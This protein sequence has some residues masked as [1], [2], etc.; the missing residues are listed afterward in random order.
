MIIGNSFFRVYTQPP[1][2]SSLIRKNMSEETPEEVK[3]TVPPV[4]QI[5]DLPKVEEEKDEAEVDEP[6]AE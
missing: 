3:T 5:T 4:T 2:L 6:K 1:G